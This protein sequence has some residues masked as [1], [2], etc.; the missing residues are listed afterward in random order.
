M[1]PIYLDHNAT[2]PTRPEVVEAMARCYAEGY[3]NPASQHR[4]GQQA[5]RVLEDARE[6]IAE[7]LDADLAPPRRDRL[8]FTSGG[9]EA[10]NLAISASLGRSPLAAAARAGAAR[11]DHHL[12]RRTSERDRAGRTPLGAGLAAGHFG[13][14]SPGR[15]PRGTVA[16]SLLVIGR[17]SDLVARV[18]SACSWATTRRACCSRS[19]NWRRSATGPACR[20]TPTPSRSWANCR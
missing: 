6:R 13:P 7:I 5:R 18:W 17:T 16:A 4:P 19:P 8:I 1:E 9:T 20:C 11:P 15:R 12:R 3:A 14:D 2:T 10:N